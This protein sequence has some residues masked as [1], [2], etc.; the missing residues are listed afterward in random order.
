MARKARRTWPQRLTIALL[1]VTSL[2]ALGTAGGLAA[3]Q[4]VVSDR[5]LVEISGT[6][7]GNGA[8]GRPHVVVPG[9]TTAT[10]PSSG[11]L[12]TPATV[13][14]AEPDA[15]NFLLVGAD[16]GNCLADDPTVG[17]RDGVQRSDTVM[18]WRV[19][20]STNQVAVL[21]FPRDLY[22]E[23]PSLGRKGRINEAYRNGPQA[24]IDTIGANFGVP[25]DH[26][27]EVDFCAFVALVDAVGGVTVPFQTAA[28][29]R[30]VA[31]E[32]PAGCQNLDGIT[33]LRY[34]R[35]R[36]FQ[37][38]RDNGTWSTDQSADFG[39]IARQ[40]DFIR[41]V[42]AKV[43]SDELYRPDTISAL[44]DTNRQ[45]L[46]TDAELTPR[47]IIE[48]ANV[49]RRVNPA[50]IATYRIASRGRNVGGAA[51][52]EPLTGSENMKA[53]LEVFRGRATLA[54]APEQTFDTTV[55]ESPATTA[56]AT[57][58]DGAPM[59]TVVVPVET[60]GVSPDPTATC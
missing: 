57:D 46:K 14:I 60:E 39:R 8:D 24:L 18:V 51:M 3:G 37:T 13:P 9:G 23:L 48:F 15:A 43:V 42:L 47:K 2:A 35:S 7:A 50:E 59:P 41:R 10:T 56:P 52:Q 54:S 45:Y 19:N 11:S 16:G 58:A 44:I 30:S 38:Q 34:V 32:V 22:V 5:Q 55:P 26:F 1:V 12:A 49:M 25:V 4:W 31:F 33:A 29:D 36:H 6:S 21:S 17:R 27:I 20:P 53:I 40:Q 28:R